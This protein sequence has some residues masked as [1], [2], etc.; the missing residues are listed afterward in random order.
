MIRIDERDNLGEGTKSGRWEENVGEHERENSEM[1][2]LK[3]MIVRKNKNKKNV[4]FKDFFK[5]KAKPQC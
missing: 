1:I 2:L 4:H 3:V 5:D